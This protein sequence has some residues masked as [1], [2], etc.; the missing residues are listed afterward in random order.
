[1]TSVRSCPQSE[2]TGAASVFNRAME[3]DRTYFELGAKTERL[4]GAVL[5]W[6]PELTASP[7]AAVIHRVEPAVIAA[8]GET[9]IV[10]A[11]RALAQVGAGL[12]RIY[13]DASE[14]AADELLRGAGYADRDELIFAHSLWEPSTWPD[15][16]AGQE[17]RGLGAEAAVPRG[18]PDYPRRPPQS[19]VRL[20]RSR[21]AKMRGRNACLSGRS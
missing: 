5:A 21:A 4:P 15:L 9:W 7:A 6:M 3:T 10:E 11:E 19:P 17:R 18:R 14:S 12:A 8:L 16:A 13:I 1:M 20:G 2:P